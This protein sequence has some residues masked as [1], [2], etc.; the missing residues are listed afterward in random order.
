MIIITIIILSLFQ[1]PPGDPGPA[2]S[3]GGKGIKVTGFS[4]FG[5]SMYSCRDRKYAK[6]FISHGK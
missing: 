5:L 1:G 6:V 2:G 4:L 3:N